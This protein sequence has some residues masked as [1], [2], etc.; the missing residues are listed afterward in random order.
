MSL[1][2]DDY[3][4]FHLL[5]NVKATHPLPEGELRFQVKVSKYHKNINSKRGSGLVCA[6]LF[7][8]SLVRSL[9]FPTAALSC[10]VKSEKS[11]DARTPFSL[12]S[13][14]V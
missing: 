10:L 7:A 11:P 6:A 14:P 12:E 5:P 13:S 2:S 3:A 9:H 4:F 1:L 8:Q